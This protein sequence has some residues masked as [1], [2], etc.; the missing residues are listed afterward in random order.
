[1]L[2]EMR[3]NKQ[4]KPRYL[5]HLKQKGKQLPVRLI[6]PDDHHQT[7]TAI[8]ASSSNAV[9]NYFVTITFQPDDTIVA[10][11]TCP[12]AEH[13]GIA[14]SHVLAALTKLAKRK[15]H[16]LSFWSTRAEAVRQKHVLSSLVSKP[17][18]EQIWITSRPTSNTTALSESRSM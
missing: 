8:V 12:W 3:V 1:M 13:G 2:I 5:R 14:C 15:H 4:M 7:W 11:C 16:T 9:F 18:D 6:A 17:P 10:R